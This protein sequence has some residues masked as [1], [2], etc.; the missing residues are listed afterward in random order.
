[1]KVEVDVLGYL[2]LIVLPFSVDIKATL[3][4][5]DRTKEMCES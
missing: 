2:S 3:K 1:M 5:E 4:W